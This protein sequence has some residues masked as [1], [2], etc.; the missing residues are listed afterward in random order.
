[1]VSR[2]CPCT[3]RVVIWALTVSLLAMA[4]APFRDHALAAAQVQTEIE[5]E[6]GVVIDWDTPWQF[7]SIV[8]DPSL[9]LEAMG[10]TDGRGHVHVA[11][12]AVGTEIAVAQDAIIRDLPY[13]PPDATNVDSG[14]SG[15]IAYSLTLL[16]RS[17]P[18][19]NLGMFTLLSDDSAREVSLVQVFIADLDDFSALFADA[20]ASFTVDGGP[21]FNGVDGA[22][23]VS[24]LRAGNTEPGDS[25]SLGDPDASNHSPVAGDDAALGII[26]DTMYRSPQ[27]D[28]KVTWDENWELDPWLPDPVV[29]DQVNQFDLVTLAW[30]DTGAIWVM[31]TFASYPGQNVSDVVDYLSST[32]RLEFDLGETAEV[33]IADSD[34]GVGGVVTRF[35]AQDGSEFLLYE[36]VREL[37]NQGTFVVIQFWGEVDRIAESLPE[38]TDGI[39]LDGETILDYFT[40]AQVTGEAP[41]SSI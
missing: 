24:Q 4:A 9:T 29:S 36:E 35:V 7:E 41:A 8:F 25:A 17:D 16:Q 38:A 21:L 37:D 14:A 15:T 11:T 10:F 18:E 31:A 30:T 39:Q 26:S 13:V 3:T 1:M 2:V 6:S 20:Q 33:I 34:V 22:G 32:G 19:D 27:F 28:Y 40:V 5:T 23:L 12:L